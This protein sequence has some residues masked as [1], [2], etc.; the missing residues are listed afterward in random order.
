MKKTHV[1]SVIIPVYNEAK[2]IAQSI[3]K[4]KK[5][6]IRGIK[7]QIVI[8]DDGSTDG[9]AAVL[10]K[11]ASRDRSLKAVFCPKNCGKGAAIREAVKYINGDFT[12]I[13]DADLEYDPEDYGLLLE[14]MLRGNADVVYGSRFL[15]THRSF[16]FW[17]LVG[18]KV[19][20]LITNIMY[21]NTLTDMET[22]YKL[23]KTP[24][25]K[26][27]KLKSSRFEI[28]PEMTAK[29]LKKHYKIYEVPIH[30]YGRGYD[31]GKKIRA[32]DG[33]GA[34]WALIKYRFVD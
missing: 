3:N 26:E 2:T 22:C 27:M 16:L 29:V 1:L 11:L 15:G 12:I 10:K 31:E 4:V 28:E 8:V 19:L 6:S 34:L 32:V 17:H 24:I 25:L 13:Q 5:A 23:F 33:F 14:P 30:F 9:T 21:N 7:K 20:T 18:N